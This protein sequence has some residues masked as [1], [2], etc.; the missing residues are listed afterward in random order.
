MVS[1]TTSGEVVLSGDANDKAGPSGAYNGRVSG[2]GA[3]MPGVAA[4]ALV[5]K[6][7]PSAPFGIGGQSQALSMPGSGTL[8]LAVNDDNPGDNR[9]EFRVKVTIV[10]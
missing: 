2:G 4:G 7:G 1:F 5:G 8:L 10:R 6:V 3:P 9:G